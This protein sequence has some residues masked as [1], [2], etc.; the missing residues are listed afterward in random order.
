MNKSNFVFFVGIFLFLIMSG[1]I[2]AEEV[3]YSYSYSYDGIQVTILKYE[4]YPANP[5]EYVDV[6]IE[7]NL[8]SSVKYAKFELLEDFPFSLDDGDD[9]IRIF[10]NYQGD[11]LMHYKVRVDEDAV[12]G[13]NTLSLKI[14]SGKYSETS[15]VFDMDVYVADA[16]TDFDL[17]LQDSSD[18]EISLAIANV[19]K[20]TANSMI[21]R[22]PDQESYSATGTSGQ[23]VGNLDSGDYTIVSFDISENRNS[24]GVLEVQIDYTDSIGERRSVTKEINVGTGSMVASNGTMTDENFSGNFPAGMEGMMMGGFNQQKKSKWPY[25]VAV[26]VVLFVAVFF[27]YYKNPRKFKEFFKKKREESK[28]EKGNSLPEW[29]VKENKKIKKE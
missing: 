24:D 18:S 23:M 25:F 29:M 6:W 5:G 19:G 4:P 11:V 22:I 26:G 1:V 12:E 3:N 2:S 21:V 28:K 13:D 10:D 16:Q 15:S 7:A 8:G 14:T 17:V 9:P 27:M 20:N